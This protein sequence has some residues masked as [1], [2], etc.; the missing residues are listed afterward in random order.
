[1]RGGNAQKPGRDIV[2]GIVPKNGCRRPAQRPGQILGFMNTWVVIYRFAWFLVILLIVIGITLIFL[3]KC[4]QYRELQ[5]KKAAIEEE[6][7]SIEAAV[8]KAQIQQEQLQWDAAFVE[9]VAREQGMVK[10]GE[11]V[12][13]LTHEAAPL[14]TLRRK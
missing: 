11:T 6:T 9:R 13:K 10:P 2:S 14:G 3:P 4:R 1:M 8:K 12:F 5:G 7:R